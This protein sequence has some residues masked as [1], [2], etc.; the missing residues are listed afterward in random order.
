MNKKNQKIQSEISK[1]LMTKPHLM[2]KPHQNTIQTNKKTKNHIKKNGTC[3][4]IILKKTQNK[5]ELEQNK[6]KLKQR[7]KKQNQNQ[8]KTRNETRLRPKKTTKKT[9]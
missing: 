1:N 9:N 5:T 2:I 7:P 8:N 4:K 6:L 3:A